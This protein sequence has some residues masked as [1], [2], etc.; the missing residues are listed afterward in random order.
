MYNRIALCVFI[1]TS[2]ETFGTHNLEKVFI[3]KNRNI[4]INFDIPEKK[5][6]ISKYIK[7]LNN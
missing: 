3:Q 4:I 1:K 7:L 5:N 6:L 2:R